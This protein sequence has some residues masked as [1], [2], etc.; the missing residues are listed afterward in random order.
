MGLAFVAMSR[1]TAWME[2]AFRNL[3]GFWEF[4]KVL[5]DQLIK[6]RK[7]FE[8]RM[9]ALHDD[10]MGKHKG[11][12]WTTED[13]IDAHVQWS[14]A[15][16]GRHLETDERVDLRSMLSVRWVLLAPEYDDEPSRGPSGLRG[17]GGKKQRLGMR[18]P[19][20]AERGR[21]VAAAAAADGQR[22]KP[23]DPS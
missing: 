17:G 23:L 14:E 6:L 16:F 19:S 5:E 12:A 3:P 15:E 2:Q 1:C 9:D 13:D 8:E 20:A 10:T 18:P 21:N 4:R 7:A 22:V 11:H